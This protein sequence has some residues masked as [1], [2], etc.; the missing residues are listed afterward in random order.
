MTHALERSYV[1]DNTSGRH[2]KTYRVQMIKQGDGWLVNTQHGPIGGALKAGTKTPSPVPYAKAV[3]AFDSLVKSKVQKSGYEIMCRGQDAEQGEP[4]ASITPITRERVD[5]KVMLLNPIAPQ[6][7]DPLL[8]DPAWCVEVKHDGE[9]RLIVI[10]QD[11]AYGVNR[12]GYKVPLAPA[13]RQ[14]ALAAPLRGRTVLDGEDMGDHVVVFDVL[15]L[16]GQDLTH[17]PL[18][19]RL[20][21][22]DAVRARIPG[23]R[24]TLTATSAQDKRAMLLT[25]QSTQQEGVVLKRLDAPHEAGRPNSGGPA[26]K[27][28]FY[29]SASCR[30][31][32]I[33]PTKR[34]VGV[35]LFDGGTGQW[36]E[37]GNVTIPANH[38]VPSVFDIVEVRYLY[39]RR[40]GALYQPVYLGQRTDLAE[41]DCQ[42]SQLKFVDDREPERLA[43]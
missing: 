29:E 30:V 4:V 1:L 22:R 3:K 23:L 26:L 14:A 5:V 40:G 16:D 18:R 42:L 7:A 21:Y 6:D 11:D 8:D 25:A 38:E 34:S 31:A 9:R 33:N 43:A 39:A 2:N 28:K 32:T 36:H 17:L 35:E 19:R 20:S 27:W 13:I 12:T 41:T 24:Y 37:A 15:M 10:D